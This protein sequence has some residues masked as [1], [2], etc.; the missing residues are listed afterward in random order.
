MVNLGNDWDNIL[1]DEFNKP[2]YM[3]LREYLRAEYH[4]HTVYPAMGDI[5]NALKYTSFK[6]DFRGNKTLPIFFPIKN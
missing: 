5:F 4:K 3:L 2:Y 6:E 1:K